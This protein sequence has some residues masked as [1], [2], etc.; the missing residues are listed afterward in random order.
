[1]INSSKDGYK[2]LALYAR[3]AEDP[4]I[5]NKNCNTK[6][7]ILCNNYSSRKMY[8]TNLSEKIEENKWNTV[9]ERLIILDEENFEKLGINLEDLVDGYVQAVL[10]TI[11]I[12]KMATKLWCNENKTFNKDL[13]NSLN[14]DNALKNEIYIL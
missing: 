9:T 8:L 12:D 13:F 5:S 4:L 1:M 2:P 7:N 6:D 11:A 10:A 3:K 14:N